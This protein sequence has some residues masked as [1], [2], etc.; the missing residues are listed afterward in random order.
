MLTRFWNDES[1]ATV[2]EYG[3]IV[4]A[5]SLVI[6]AAVATVADSLQALFGDPAGKLQQTLN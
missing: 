3:I 6:V 1:G 5:L 2:V 4:V